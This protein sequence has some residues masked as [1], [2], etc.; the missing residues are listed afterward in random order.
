MT[1]LRRHASIVW[2]ALLAACA[3]VP[4]GHDGSYLPDPSLPRLTVASS[5]PI[6]DQEPILVP[7]GRKNF[8]ITWQLPR[9]SNYRFAR[10][11][12]AITDPQEQFYDCRA[13]DDGM[14]FSCINR[15]TVPGLIKY[16]V[17]VLEGV[18][19]LEA[20]TPTIRNQ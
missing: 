6:I 1:H 2:P 9:G 11:G 15:N 10:N 5:Q 3:Q 14:T 13:A 20:I 18:R 17:T 4:S 7:A 12:I 8:R 16:R 19:P